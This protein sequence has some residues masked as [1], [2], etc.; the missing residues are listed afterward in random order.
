MPI[1]K[2][3]ENIRKFESVGFTHEQAEILADVIE[4]SHVN[5]QQSL[6][7]FLNDKFKEVGIEFKDLRN[8]IENRFKEVRSEIKTSELQ[9]KASLTDLLMKIFAIVVGCTSIAIAISKVWK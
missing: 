2:E 1:T 9:M 6:K 8:D 4:L 3:L 7:E 5:G